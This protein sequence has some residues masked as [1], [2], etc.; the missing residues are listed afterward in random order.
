MT[1]QDSSQVSTSI[2]SLEKLEATPQG[3][4][5][6]WMA[7]ITQAETELKHF[8][9]SG[10]GVVAKYND[11]RDEVSKSNKWINIFNA[12]VGILEASLYS[13]IPTIDITRRVPRFQ[14]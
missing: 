7:E 3:K 10:K 14:R 4:Y 12:N 1:Q 6:R 8:I 5:D 2:D 9:K 11:D 13:T